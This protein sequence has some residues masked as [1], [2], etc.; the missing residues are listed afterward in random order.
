MVHNDP[1]AREELKKYHETAGKIA[2][3]SL[4]AASTAGTAL[5]YGI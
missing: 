3:I 1:K 5:T 2:G 4:A